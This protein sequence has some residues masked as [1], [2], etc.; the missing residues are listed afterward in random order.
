MSRFPCYATVGSLVLI[1]VLLTD[2]RGDDF[3]KQLNRLDR[4]PF[5]TLS[6]QQKRAEYL[7]LIEQNPDHPDRAIAMFRL[8]HLY[9]ITNPAIGQT[10]DSEQCVIWLQKSRQ[11]AKPGSDVWL[12]ATF[13]LAGHLPMDAIEERK[14]L[15]NEIL[16]ET[17]DPIMSARAYYNL[18]VLAVREKNYQEAERICHMLQDWMPD[19]EKQ[20]EAMLDKGKFFQEIQSS[21]TY[22]LIVY[23]EMSDVPTETRRA[24][25]EA[26]FEKYHGRQYMYGARDRAIAHLDLIIKLTTPDR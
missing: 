19:K 2:V 16:R 24:K 21:A 22:M 18:Q 12:N 3:T 9:R 13:H 7:Q 5:E 11:A 8:A 25:I 10:P 23:S 1:G 15:Q 6:P 14:S 17:S 4:T 20:P 26:F